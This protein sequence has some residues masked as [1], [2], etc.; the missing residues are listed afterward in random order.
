MEDDAKGGRAVVALDPLVAGEVVAVWNG[1]ILTR[2]QVAALPEI[3]R[4]HTAQ[5]EEGL[6]L[7]STGENEPPDFINH[8]CE[9]NAGMSG[10][11]AIVAMRDI[12]AG[13]EITIDYAMCDGSPFDEFACACGSRL[14]RGNVTGD[15]WRRPELWARYGQHFSPYLLRRIAALRAELG[16]MRLVVSQPADRKRP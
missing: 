1:R 2:A 14:C 4:A 10:Q 16:V 9:P 15:D 8:S 6:Y 13:E 11:I 5:V 12:A 3:L 7:T